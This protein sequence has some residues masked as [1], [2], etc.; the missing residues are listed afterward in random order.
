MIKAGE[1]TAVKGVNRG[2]KEDIGN[3]FNNKDK[4]KEDNMK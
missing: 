1:G 4:F 2:K 3:N